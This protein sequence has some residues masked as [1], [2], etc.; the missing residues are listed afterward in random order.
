MKKTA[1]RVILKISSVMQKHLRIHFSESTL[2]IC[3]TIYACS[4]CSLFQKS[5]MYMYNDPMKEEELISV[6]QK[7]VSNFFQFV[8]GK[9][10]SFQINLSY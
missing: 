7:Q 9:V 6:I 8:R 4:K 5:Y 2:N 3:M 1:M 10:T